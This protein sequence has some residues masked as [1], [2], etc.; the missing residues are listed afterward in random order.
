MRRREFINALGAAM[1][2][3]MIDPPIRVA[4]NAPAAKAFAQTSPRTVRCYRLITTGPRPMWM[5]AGTPSQFRSRSFTGRS[6]M[7]QSKI[8]LKAGLAIGLLAG[9]LLPA[10][11]A[12]H[13]MPH[14][15]RSTW[16][17][18]TLPG[19]YNDGHLGPL[20]SADGRVTAAGAEFERQITHRKGCDNHP[21]LSA[22][23]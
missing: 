2:P 7:L 23:M 5:M 18:E 20:M 4:Q 11:A 13:A 10:T 1:G 8:I 16:T 14:F 9:T 3:T 21:N 12:P 22:C 15:P 19:A 6:Q 17:V